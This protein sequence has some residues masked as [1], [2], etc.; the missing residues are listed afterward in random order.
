MLHLK[1]TFVDKFSVANVDPNTEDSP[2]P[3][4]APTDHQHTPTHQ[5][6]AQHGENSK[7][8]KDVT[9]NFTDGVD[10]VNNVFNGSWSGV[11]KSRVNGFEGGRWGSMLTYDTETDKIK[12]WFSEIRN[13]P[14]HK[15]I[16]ILKGY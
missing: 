7:I 15:Q 6:T 8:R 13:V 2:I 9:M 11:V 10:H 1:I 5:K 12:K 4:P 16:V 3:S 14:I